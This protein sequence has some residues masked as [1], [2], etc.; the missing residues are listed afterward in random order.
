MKNK[1]SMN[2]KCCG[3]ISWHKSIH[4]LFKQTLAHN[5]HMCTLAINSRRLVLNWDRTRLMHQV[6]TI[7]MHTLTSWPPWGGEARTV[8][9]HDER[10][11]LF[12]HHEEVR[13]GLFRHHEEVRPGLFSHIVLNQNFF[14]K[15]WA[16]QPSFRIFYTSTLCIYQ[17]SKFDITSE[18]TFI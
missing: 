10:P 7:K 1:L 5:L 13:P 8:C 9:H 12:H 3:N 16:E 11:G 4:I 18:M 17:Y 2:R 14:N 6:L 15:I